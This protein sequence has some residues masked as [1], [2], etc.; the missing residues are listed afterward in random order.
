[1]KPPR[2]GVPHSMAEPTPEI[3]EP[4]AMILTCPKLWASG[5]AA[6]DV[7]APGM[8]TEETMTPWT[9]ALKVPKLDEK[10]GIVVTGPIMPVSNLTNINILMTSKSRRKRPI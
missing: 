5:P 10:A 2:L 9:V 1:M 7:I 8:R 4:M 3:N 6:R